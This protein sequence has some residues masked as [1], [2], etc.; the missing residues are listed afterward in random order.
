MKWMMSL[1]GS[2][3][4]WAAAPNAYIVI[5]SSDFTYVKGQTVHLQAFSDQQNTQFRWQ[6][7]TGEV[8][9]G[10]AT[11]FVLNQDGPISVT[12]TATN[13]IGESASPDDRILYSIEVFETLNQPRVLGLH[14]SQSAVH[15]GMPFSIE[16]DI[17]DA[18]QDGPYEYH[19]F[20]LE[21]NRPRRSVGQV[22][23][24]GLPLPPNPGFAYAVYV[25]VFDAAGN[26]SY[27]IP[28]AIYV[29]EGNLP[30]TGR[31][32]EPS[33]SKVNV[34][35]GQEVSFLGGG[36]D[37][38][39]DEPLSFRWL[40]PNLGTVTQNPVSHT[41]NEVGFFT[42]GLT[43][44][45]SK[46]NADPALKTVLVEVFEQGAIDPP[47]VGISKPLLSTRIF[48]E[49]SLILSGFG[50]TGLD[51]RWIVRD[52]VTGEQTAEVLGSQP[53]RL[54]FPHAGLYQLLFE[55]ELLGV[56]S[57]ALDSNTRWIAVHKRDDNRAPVVDYADGV[58]QH[59]VRNGETINLTVKT[60]DPDE[61][62]VRLFWVQDGKLLGEGSAQRSVRFDLEEEDFFKGVANKSV[63][64][65][66]LDARGKATQR[67][68]FHAFTIYQDRVP[69]TPMINALASGTTLFLPVG[70]TYEL[71]STVINPDDVPL[72][73]LWQGL[74]L[75]E[76]AF[77][78]ESD[79]ASPGAV[80]L[81]KP[82]IA[83]LTLSLETPDGSLRGSQTH[84]LW[85][86][87]YDPDQKPRAT[88]TKPVVSFLRTEPGRPVTL[89]GFASDPNFRESPF[90]E[91]ELFQPVTH[92][93][94]WEVSS[95]SGF[96]ESHA[97][98]GPLIL[99]LEEP[100]VYTVALS[101]RNNLGL[102]TAQPAQITLEVAAP[103]ND[104]L[105]EPNDRREDAAPLP[106]G[107]YAGL[108]VGPDDPEDW[109]RFDLEKAGS[110][111]ELELDLREAG[112]PVL[113]E[114][115]RGE[116]RVQFSELAGGSKHPFSFAGSAAGTY[117]LRL[118]ATGT[119]KALTGLDFSFAVSVSTP[120]LTFSYVKHDEVDETLLTL[121]NPFGEAADVTLTARGVNGAE[122]ARAETEIAA[123]GLLEQG[124][125]DFFP[126]VDTLGIAWIQVLSDQN[127]IGLSTTLARDEQSAVA[128][129]A[130]IG[131]LDRLVI[132]HIAQNTE[133]W[134]TRAALANSS[135]EP[136]QPLFRAQAGEF[137]VPGFDQ[138]HQGSFLDFEAFFG[139]SLPSGSE[140][141]QFVEAAAK[142]GLSGM[143]L[144]GT[145][146]GQ[147]RLAGLT[148][149][150]DRWINPNFTYVNRD[151]YFPHVAKDTN[152]FWTGIA[153]VNTGS[154]PTEIMLIAR[155]DQGGVLSQRSMEVP[156][157]GKQVGLAHDFF[158]DLGPD[159]GIS[160]IQLKTGG[161][162]SGYEL[163]GDN[164]GKNETLAG[165][166]A[167]RGGSREIIF[168]KVL[169]QAGKYW[170][171]VAIVNL[172]PDQNANLVYQAYNAE[173][174]LLARVDNRVI[175]PYR[176][177]VALVEAIFG[178]VLPEG[179]RWIRLTSSQPLAA[180]ELFGDHQGHFLAG[181][182]A[183]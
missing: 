12:M 78:F 61:D 79:Q 84:L 135:G 80:S 55:A 90:D 37:P 85:L 169:H 137:P 126:G 29:L 128:E 108:S 26:P 136:I 13:A 74:Y 17:E 123:G 86:H 170:T 28:T 71:N 150:S 91:I 118:A 59:L 43:A 176:K 81:P 7:S 106:F 6:L 72:T 107:S 183:Q 158:P 2:G 177:E 63:Q 14:P 46:G 144:F 182:V 83:S 69:P 130:I 110:L 172:S 152:S 53:G 120:R 157:F 156:S 92:Q 57:E 30:P 173:G 68:L 175:G 3:W 165:F 159:S 56:K 164:T 75:G 143:E 76:L 109:F 20:W 60:E 35:R 21:D 1:L 105:Y 97:P 45:D 99:A 77:F 178:G 24:S 47:I 98:E 121:L 5:P 100:G 82:G 27:A 124:V 116:D 101:A 103:A 40:L 66:G 138:A 19:L 42:V 87:V 114:V 48:E 139:G 111:L 171:G 54:E 134:F 33:D 151:I 70:A 89:E 160:W 179:A 122:L 23:Q 149:T 141:G 8:L 62:S 49:E 58:F 168:Q 34:I 181:T 162:I 31:V 166:P 18:D 142:P 155:D 73:Y 10:A 132:P 163:F 88:I 51:T 39:G 32:L 16:A 145:K 50:P 148:L 113:V 167:I 146:V 147:P 4:L 119:G 174:D 9:E 104:D 102:S 11:S 44:V 95:P 25:M 140:W 131:G 64:T 180:F 67:P 22:L 65:L 161:A 96:F 133:Q 15:P 112:S 38:E 129:P 94:T 125:S 52:V 127:I 36:F 154:E 115:Y 93:L 41:F 117:F 153:F